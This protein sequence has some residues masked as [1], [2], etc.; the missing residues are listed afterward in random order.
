MYRVRAHNPDTASENRIHSDDVARDYGFEGGLVPGVIVHAYMTRAA[1]D[2]WG[3]PWLERGTTT[4]RLHKPVYDGDDIT[5]D[6]TTTTGGLD[7]E[8][9][10]PEDEIAANGVATLPDAA[11]SF[12]LDDYPTAPLP[13]D[14]PPAGPESLAKE[15]VL[16]TFEVGFRA[17]R[18]HEYLDM[19]SDD[20]AVYRTERVA[21]PGWLMLTAN[22]ILG[23]NVRL[24][25]WIHVETEAEHLGL[26]RD[27]DRV[28]T[29]G[30][31]TD[32]FE[33]KGHKFV[34]LDLLWV[35]NGERQVMHARHVAI[36]EPR[37][38]RNDGT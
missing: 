35:A 27:G 12:D 24:G 31:V 38:R 11:P 14:R 17:D 20:C 5:I 15:T 25:P 36:Y 23:S 34:E 8:V 22:Y 21:H 16:G 7:L 3:L 19:I 29:R 26:V 37:R 33:R 2:R 6:A 28:A 30:R 1:V 10:T 18:A 32:C 13:D 9:R 4:V